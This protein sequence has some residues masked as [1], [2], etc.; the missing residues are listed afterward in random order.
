[1]KSEVKKLGVGETLYNLI[2]LLN[3]TVSFFRAIKLSKLDQI[4]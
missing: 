2:D 4:E 1:M 3:P